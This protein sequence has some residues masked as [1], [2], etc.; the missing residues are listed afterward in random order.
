MASGTVLVDD[1]GPDLLES[2][3]DGDVVTVVDNEVWRGEEQLASGVRRDVHELEAAHRGGPPHARGRAREVRHQHPP[4]PQARAP[5]GHRQP[6]PAPRADVV[7]GP[8]RPRRG[9]GHRLPRGPGRAEALRLPAGG[10]ARHDRGRRWRR[11]A[12]GAR[13]QARHHH[14]R[15]RLRVRRG[16]ALRC[17]AHRA[18][19]PRRQGAWC[20]SADG[21]RAA[22][23]AVRDC[24]HERGH[25][26]APGPRARRAA[27]RR[28]GH[29]QLDGGVPRQGPRR[30]GLHLPRPAAGRRVARRRQGRQPPLPARS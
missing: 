2:L 7:Q 5:P 1:L 8:P 9:A 4:V 15:L 29:A 14:G 24:G 22:L 27:H 30:H 26:A 13:H 21:A 25:R 3:H 10:Q 12:A 20:G 17:G 23:R 11:R 19:L 6:G 16:H 28:R 18:R